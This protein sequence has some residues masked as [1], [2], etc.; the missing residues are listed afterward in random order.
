MQSIVCTV[1]LDENEF[2]SEEIDLEGQC[3]NG[4]VQNSAASCPVNLQY[5]GSNVNL[6][7][8]QNIPTESEF[9]S[10]SRSES[11][12]KAHLCCGDIMYSIN[13]LFCTTSVI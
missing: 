12:I 9:S 1:V 10:R 6:P 3:G 2:L 4:E 13:T 8:I 11:Q 5:V 7:A